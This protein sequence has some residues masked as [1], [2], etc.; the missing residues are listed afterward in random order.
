MCEDN[1]WDEKKNIY[2]RY[3]YIRILSVYP[4]SL[5]FLSLAFPFFQAF[6]LLLSFT[7]HLSNFFT[8][9][10]SPWFPSVPFHTFSTAL[11]HLTPARP[12][13]TFSRTALTA[14]V[15]NLFFGAGGGCY[16]MTRVI[17]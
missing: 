1:E 9:I 15:G 5:C 4:I 16:L 17:T 8:G 11:S 2:T 6:V 14:M 3:I 13:V 12:F 7:R 10:I